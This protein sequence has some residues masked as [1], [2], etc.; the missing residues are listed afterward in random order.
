MK[1]SPSRGFTLIELLVVIAIIAILAAIL[2]PVF[3]QAREK[4]RQTVC[5][6]NLKQTST[7]TM[8]Y[9]QDYDERMPQAVPNGRISSFTTPW[10]RV[11]PSSAL[12]ASLLQAFWTNAIQSYV[13]NWGT[14]DCPSPTA[15][16]GG[17]PATLNDAKYPIAETYNGYLHAWPLAGSPAPANVMMFSIGYGKKK[18]KGYGDIFPLPGTAG[19]CGVGTAGGDW[20]FARSGA[21]CTTA[22][23]YTGTY[24]AG[25]PSPWIHGQGE[26]QSYMDGHA[27]WVRQTSDRSVWDGVDASGSLT[28]GFW[29][30]SVDGAAGCDYFFNASPTAE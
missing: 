30:D 17:F 1:R 2:F 6:S 12:S 19:A 5:V 4:A 11:P 15:D 21:A 28:G 20:Q 25:T 9:V 26:N 29:V 14:Y 10:D 27:K 24:G 8:M 3:A 22:C 16:N 23:A 13:K 18:K 7:A